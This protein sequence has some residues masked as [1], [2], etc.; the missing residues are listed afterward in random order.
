MVKDDPSALIQLI[1]G[2]TCWRFVGTTD[3]SGEHFRRPAILRCRRAES[4]KTPNRVGLPARIRYV[5][6]I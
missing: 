2:L 6:Q 1:Q 4:G 5:R 3:L